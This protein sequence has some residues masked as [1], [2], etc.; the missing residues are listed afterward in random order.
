M[1]TK[2]FT[3]TQLR[4][5]KQLGNQLQ[6]ANTVAA[7]ALLTLHRFRPD[8]KR[9]E[10]VCIDLTNIVRRMNFLI[11]YCE[12]IATGSF[13]KQITRI[14]AVFGI[15]CE[16]CENTARSAYRSSGQG[17]IGTLEADPAW[18]V[19]VEYLLLH[20]ISTI[21]RAE[22]AECS[23]L[24]EFA[25]SPRCLHDLIKSLLRQQRHLGRMGGARAPEI[26]VIHDDAEFC[27]ECGNPYTVGSL[28]D[29]EDANRQE[30]L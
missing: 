30:S 19:L 16:Y 3:E 24:R 28:V 25:E 7:Q 13:Q 2:S 5:H 23:S 6:I 29:D 1:D 27:S 14:E 15:T 18:D 10:Q 4:Q 8:Q 9:H 26:V 21:S 17:S 22:G 11:G 20:A 12:R